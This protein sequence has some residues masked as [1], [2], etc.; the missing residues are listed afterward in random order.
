[1]A[2]INNAA[3][4][5]MTSVPTPIPLTARPDA[6]TAASDEPSLH[7]TQ[8]RNIGKTDA[9]PDAEAVSR[10]D[11]RQAAR[12]ACDSKAEAGED[13]ADYCKKP[14]AKT[15]GERSADEAQG[16]IQEP[17]TEKTSETDPREAAK[18]RCNDAMKAL[19]V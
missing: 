15:V 3:A 4:G 1:M 2:S 18:S 13:H 19:N 10:V 14:G 11:F 8:D 16:E 12:Q 6:K 5:G 9:K 7:G 17:A